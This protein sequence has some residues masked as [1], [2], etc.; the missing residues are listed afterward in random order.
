[1]YDYIRD[2]SSKPMCTMEAVVSAAAKDVLDLD[3]SLILVVTTTGVPAHL[4]TKYRPKVSSAPMPWLEFPLP[5]WCCMHSYLAC[6]PWMSARHQCIIAELVTWPMQW[7]YMK[8]AGYVCCGI[9]TTRPCLQVPVL[10]VT[11]SESVA[12]QCGLHYALHPYV[13][14]ALPASRQDVEFD[15]LL[16]EA[17][18]VAVDRQ[19]LRPGGE[20][21]VIH[22][23]KGAAA[24]QCPML[25]IKVRAA[26]E[27]AFQCSQACPACH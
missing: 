20:V 6:L 21:V 13:V 14:P 7:C 26:A 24:E 4:I 27:P 22:G 12:R 2:F 9:L 25:T 23:Y 5:V 1:V 18:L 10:V 17:L 19:L 8:L 16:E 3:A 15:V 11:P